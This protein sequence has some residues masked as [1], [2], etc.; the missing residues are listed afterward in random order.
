MQ[1]KSKYGK[2]YNFKFVQNNKS[3]QIVYKIRKNYNYDYN[4]MIMF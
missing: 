1:Q 4:E 2:M 3:V